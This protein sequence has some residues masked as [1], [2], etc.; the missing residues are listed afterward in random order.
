MS[1]SE[2]EQISKVWAEASSRG[3]SGVLA[4][5]V[6]NHGSTYRKAGARLL[7]TSSGR[8]SG[9]V[10]GGCLEA[11]LV[12]KAWWLT[13]TGNVALRRYDTTADGEIAQEFG[14][15]CNG[16]IHLLL[17][18]LGGTAISPM[19]AVELIKETRRFAVLSTLIS[20]TGDGSLRLG[21]RWLSLPDGSIRTDLPDPEICRF[22]AAE[23]ALAMDGAEPRIAS[24]QNQAQTVDVFVE[25]LFPAPRL[26]VLGAGDDA[27]SVTRLA[28]FLGYEVVVL[29]G[30]SHMARA[31]RFPHADRVIVNSKEA[32]LAGIAVDQW[33]AAV[34]MS[35]SYEQDLSALRALA[36]HPLP[37]LGILGPRKRT[38]QLLGDAGISD[39]TLGKNLHSPMGLDIGA[40]GPEQ[41][42][43][44]LIAEIQAVM[45]QRAGG[46][47]R[48]KAGPLHP[49]SKTSSDCTDFAKAGTCALDAS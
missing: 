19:S 9:A 24:W 3:E 22:L 25:P 12:K 16:V 34:L 23:S 41:I 1:F 15:G 37:Y 7:L 11:D 27:V 42:A 2:L 38:E 36:E 26:L 28:K 31:D 49:R 32:P 10:S 33:T 18:R 48:E 21:Q 13:E 43:L 39:E 35:H 6:R 5:V 45:N 44:A 4:T 47:L 20:A 46:R 17:E 8:K 30:R 40:D 14:M 29:D